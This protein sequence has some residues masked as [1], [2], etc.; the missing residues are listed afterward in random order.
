MHFLVK[1]DGL[2]NEAPKD[3]F[4][5]G[6]D[7][8]FVLRREISP[9][10]YFYEVDVEAFTKMLELGRADR[11]DRGENDG[12]DYYTDRRD[13]RHDE[14]ERDRRGYRPEL[15][16]QLVQNSINNRGSMLVEL[17][18]YKHELG[19]RETAYITERVQGL[20]R[21]FL[22]A[23]LENTS[24]QFAICPDYPG[25]PLAETNSPEDQD[26]AITN[27]YRAFLEILIKSKTCQ[28]TVTRDVSITL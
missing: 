7:E 5:D 18:R 13:R 8:A 24:A 19:T 21:T 28:I 6:R 26:E 3:V 2:D 12:R 25:R 17:I 9:G 22:K 16:Y 14:R 4:E 23:M 11:G 10:L 27:A 15:S 1:Y 20:C